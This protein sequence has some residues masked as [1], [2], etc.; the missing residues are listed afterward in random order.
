VSR[1]LLLLID[2]TANNYLRMIILRSI[3]RRNDTIQENSVFTLLARWRYNATFKDELRG[4]EPSSELSRFCQ[5][6]SHH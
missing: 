1:P 4:S 5:H 2:H 3:E 6:K